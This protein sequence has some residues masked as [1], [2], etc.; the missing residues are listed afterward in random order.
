MASTVRVMLETGAKKRA[1]ACAFDWPGWDRSARLGH[2]PMVVL[3]AY[4]PRYAR[5]AELA[6][7]GESFAALG[8]LRVVEE[9]EGTG[10]TDYYGVSGRAASGEVGAMSDAECD[11]K[12]ALL[13]AAWRTFD[14]TAARVS[15]ELRLG[16]RGG[17]RS[18]DEI[19]GHVNRAE[20]GEF[21]RKV[22]VTEPVEIWEDADALA[23]Y[24]VS[25]V[26][27]I[28]DHHARAAKAR[29][30]ELQTLIRR[31]AWHMLDHAWELED[32][33]LTDEP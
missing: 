4:R 26:D 15:A 1:V 17:G 9:L 11:R 23:A 6:G 19:V 7:Y 2:D 33:D 5:V 29:T 24:R 13:E 25:V 30:W 16:P 12:V 21:A 10:M 28:R 18:R 32:R 8:R 20:I 3:E 27:A 31:L 22:G 14:E